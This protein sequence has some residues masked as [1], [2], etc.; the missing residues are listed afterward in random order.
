MATNYSTSEIKKKKEE[1]GIE[2][3]K[4][5]DIQ[6][7]TKTVSATDKLLKR[8][9]KT[10]AKSVKD[11]VIYEFLIPNAVKLARDS[12]VNALDMFLLG[13]CGGSKASNTNYTSFSNGSSNN[14]SGS[15]WSGESN[16]QRS[17]ERLESI[18]FNSRAD[19]E[20]YLDAIRERIITFKR[21]SLLDCFDMLQKT[22]TS[23][24]DDS[25]GWRDISMAEIYACQGGFAIRYPRVIC[26][27]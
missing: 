25:Y 20:D 3:P 22:E 11:F 12:I 4:K 27:N 1:T 10:D 16:K 21:C 7:K 5:L 13:K 19:A 24:A 6:T 23:P 14:N 17:I 2:A 9:I 18:L 26:I 15:R 8:F